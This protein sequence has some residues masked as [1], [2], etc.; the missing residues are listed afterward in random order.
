MLLLLN[1]F[2]QTRGYILPFA[3][4]VK[5]SFGTAPRGAARPVSAGHTERILRVESMTSQG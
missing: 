5:P 3:R 2:H 1:P 4:F